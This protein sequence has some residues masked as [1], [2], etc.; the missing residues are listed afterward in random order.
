[1]FSL[2]TEGSAEGTAL[3][4]PPVVEMPWSKRS[5]IRGV[6]FVMLPARGPLG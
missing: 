1:M 5:G 6:K 2:F 4:L 3:E